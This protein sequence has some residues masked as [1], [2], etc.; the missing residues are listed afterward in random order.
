MIPKKHKEIVNIVSEEIDVSSELIDDLT[1]F[2]YKSMRRKLSNVEDLKFRLPGLGYF[3]IRNT[4]V[5]KAIKK[6]ESMKNGMGDAT[7]NNYHNRKIIESRLEKLYEINEKIKQ[8]METRKQ[9][10]ENKYGKQIE[11]NLEKPE[12]DI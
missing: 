3:L 2:Y 6:F 12:T 5:N 1:S 7:F 11:N 4:G 10:K 8:F 9:F